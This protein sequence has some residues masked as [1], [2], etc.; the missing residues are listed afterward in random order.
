MP[1]AKPGKIK[2]KLT[3][4]DIGRYLQEYLRA[5][6]VV[7]TMM[8]D[9]NSRKATLMAYVAE[10]GEPDEKGS[11]W[12]ELPSPVDGVGSLK[13]ERRESQ[14][15]NEEI[16]EQELRKLGLLEECQQTVV[17][18]DVDKIYGLGYEGKIPKNVMAKIIETRE[19]WAFKPIGS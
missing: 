13:R 15:L 12:V 2:R 4:R 16:A 18:L 11:L 9:V 6:A 10:N 19:S 5:K 8:T 14:F 3:A 1:T 17:V 7:D